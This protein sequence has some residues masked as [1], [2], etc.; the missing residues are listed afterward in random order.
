MMVEIPSCPLYRAEGSSSDAAL[1]F[2]L[3]TISH[4]PSVSSVTLKRR[5]RRQRGR[6]KD[7]R[8]GRRS[9]RS[10]AALLL[11]PLL[12]K[13][14]PWCCSFTALMFRRCCAA[15]L[16]F[17]RCSALSPPRCCCTIAKQRRSRRGPCSAAGEEAL[18]WV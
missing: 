6:E 14:L 3:R 13:P 7:A 17:R 11:C 10:I 5:E 2:L 18:S 9:R 15:R 4:A 1:P 16:F 12:L 8:R